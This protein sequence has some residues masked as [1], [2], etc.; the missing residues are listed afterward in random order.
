MENCAEEYATPRKVREKNLGKKS[1]AI[2]E[3]G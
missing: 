1:L 2:S 3:S